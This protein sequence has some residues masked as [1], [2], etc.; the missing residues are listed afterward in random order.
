MSYGFASIHPE[1]FPDD[2]LDQQQWFGLIGT[3]PELRRVDSIELVIPF[4]GGKVQMRVD[5][6]ELIRDGSRVG[7]FVWQNG[8]IC[9]DG[10]HSMFP[11]AQRIAQALGAHVFD[12]DTGEELLEVPND[13]EA[14]PL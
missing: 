1:K 9:V 11:M 10:P 13:A 5:G 7:L 8:K 12:D 6:A 14:N 2:R 4:L 3:I